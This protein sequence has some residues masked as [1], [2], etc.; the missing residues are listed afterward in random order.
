LFAESAG[1][2]PADASGQVVWKASYN[3]FGKASISSQPALPPLSHVKVVSVPLCTDA[4][5]IPVN[6]SCLIA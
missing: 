6:G 3:P 4:C 1:V 2:A 5:S